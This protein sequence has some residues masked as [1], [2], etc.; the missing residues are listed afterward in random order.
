MVA[1][2][3]VCG[4]A[5]QQVHMHTTRGWLDTATVVALPAGLWFQAWRWYRRFRAASV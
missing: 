2:R 4:G 1:R 3:A 5:T